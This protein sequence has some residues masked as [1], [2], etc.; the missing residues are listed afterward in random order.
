M[1][2]LIAFSSAIA[3]LNLVP[4]YALDGQHILAAVLLNRNSRHFISPHN[5]EHYP[6]T[7]NFMLTFGTSLLLLN[8]LL[9]LFSL[10][11]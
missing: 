4:C 1:K 5:D 2:Y 7:Y 11:F 9:A 10:F 6:K 8:L 3:I